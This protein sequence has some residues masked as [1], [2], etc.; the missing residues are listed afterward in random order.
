MF[1]DRLLHARHNES[2]AAW[3]RAISLTSLAVVL[4]AASGMAESAP[5]R[6]E[7]RVRAV[8]PLAQARISA[9]IGQDDDAYHTVAQPRGFRMTNADHGLSADFVP[10]GVEFRLGTNR[11]SLELRGYGYGGAL[12]EVAAVGPVAKDNRLEY[13]RGALTEWYI[14]G[15]LGLEQGFTLE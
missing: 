4:C 3:L 8:S 12:E 13:R 14:N 15:P 6:P 1:V 11:W 9:A 5:D 7:R 10:S 2:L